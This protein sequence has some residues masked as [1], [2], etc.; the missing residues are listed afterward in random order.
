MRIT[1]QKKLSGTSERVLLCFCW[2]RGAEE[3]KDP[4]RSM[5]FLHSA[6]TEKLYNIECYAHLLLWR[7]WVLYASFEWRCEDFNACISLY[8]N[9]SVYEPTA[10]LSLKLA[11][12]FIYVCV[13]ERCARPIVFLPDGLIKIKARRK[14]DSQCMQVEVHNK[15][16]CGTIHTNNLDTEMAADSL[17][18][19]VWFHCFVI[20][21]VVYK[22]SEL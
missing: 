16:S 11:T 9:L 1:T 7:I 8:E 12:I 15:K 6:E 4:G 22:L 17:Q 21:L 5:S 18:I 10:F 2:G 3:N 20:E 19:T 14:L 13:C